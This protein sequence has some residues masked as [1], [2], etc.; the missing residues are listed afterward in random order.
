MT[1]NIL[2]KKRTITQMPMASYCSRPELKVMQKK[3]RAIT[4]QKSK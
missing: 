4:A 3:R 1:L 2:T